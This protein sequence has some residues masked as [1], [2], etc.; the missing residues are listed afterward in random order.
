MMEKIS[1]VRHTFMKKKCGN[2]VTAYSFTKSCANPACTCE[3]N[4]QLGQL[5]VLDSSARHHAS[6]L[7]S[8]TLMNTTFWLSLASSANV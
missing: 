4:A 6:A 7:T 3:H 8:L 5:R 1:P 2:C